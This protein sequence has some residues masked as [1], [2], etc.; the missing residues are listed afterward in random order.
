M[1]KWHLEMSYG[2]E[3]RS[4]ERGGA[5]VTEHPAGGDEE[6]KQMYQAARRLSEAS[7]SRPCSKPLHQHCRGPV[8][9]PLF[10][11]MANHRSYRA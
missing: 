9:H 3:D 2:G 1:S 5:A 8:N 4:S 10:F 7:L 11:I 6:E